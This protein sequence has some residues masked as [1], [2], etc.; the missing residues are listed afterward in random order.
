MKLR[1]YQVD[2]IAKIRAAL[3]THKRV[4]VCCPTGSGKTAMAAHILHGAHQKENP[5]YFCV[6]RRQL[7]KQVS[8]A[9]ARQAIPHGFIAAG[10]EDGEGYVKVA[11]QQSYVRR[12]EV[13]KAALLVIDEAHLNVDTYK[14]IMEENPDAYVILLSATPELLSGRPIPADVKIETVDTAAL[15]E[16]GYLCNFKYYAPTKL[17]F[18]GCN[19]QGGDYVQS[20]IAA[21]AEQAKISGRALD[22]Y[23]EW[24][25]DGKFINFSYSIE[26]SYETALEFTRA[27]Y[28]CVH[29]D[30]ESSDEERDAA[31][32]KIELGELRG[33]SNVNL[34]AEGADCPALQVMIGQS[35]TKSMMRFRQRIGRVLRLDEDKDYAIIL[36]MVNDWKTHGWP[37]EKY[38]WQ[39]QG[40]EKRSKEKDKLVA[41]VTCADCFR[42]YPIRESFCPECG[43]VREIQAREVAQEEGKLVRL[44]REEKLAIKEGLRIERE[45]EKERKRL[46]KEKSLAEKKV[47]SNRKRIAKHLAVKAATCPKD[48]MDWAKINGYDPKYGLVLWKQFKRKSK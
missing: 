45:V 18:T 3:K 31:F 22:H 6:H 32:A 11:M 23:R 26:H 34:F 36:D 20:E 4:L 13:K 40:F 16:M 12:G 33:I 29:L 42:V 43:V 47:E 24:G 2:I 28:P 8:D 30:C 21:I 15:I 41:Y 35:P 10:F 44:T 14:K 5:A 25:E 7:I 17:D 19:S 46:E 39:W 1:N 38:D 37:D 27:G 48:L 9:L